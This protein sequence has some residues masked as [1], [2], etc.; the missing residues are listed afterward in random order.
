VA[1]VLFIAPCVLF[2]IDYKKAIIAT[3]AYLVLGTFNVL[4][5]TPVIYTW[6]FGFFSNSITAPDFSPLCLLLLVVTFILNATTLFD[7]VLDI[8]EAKTWRK[9]EKTK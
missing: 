7:M 1:L 5:L 6:S 9:S 3:L 4:S 8:K 2:Y